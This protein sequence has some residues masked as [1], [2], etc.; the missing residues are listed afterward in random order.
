[1][2]IEV[3]REEEKRE[4]R[5]RDRR[6]NRIE[7]ELE[8]ERVREREQERKRERTFFYNNNCVDLE[9]CFLLGNWNDSDGHLGFPMV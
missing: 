5:E 9:L 7:K 1:M 8:E 3:K 4:V 6:R 2:L